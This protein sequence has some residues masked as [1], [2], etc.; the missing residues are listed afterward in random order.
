MLISI[1]SL[2]QCGT[3]NDRHQ[4]RADIVIEG[5]G[6][7][8]NQRNNQIAKYDERAKKVERVGFLK[9]HAK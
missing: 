7:Y 3:H 6:Q 1:K 5:V 4:E 8:G 2:G 9:T